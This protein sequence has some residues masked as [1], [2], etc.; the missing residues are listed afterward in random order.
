[1]RLVGGWCAALVVAALGVVDGQA[2]IPVRPLGRTVAVSSVPFS[3][4]VNVRQLAN[5]R[6]LVNDTRRR[7]VLSLDSM[8]ANSV[9]VID[10]TPGVPNS[11]GT[12]ATAIFPHLGDSTLFLDPTST[13]MILLDPAGK[14]VRHLTS[15]AGALN[16]LSTPQAYGYARL[17]GRGRL[18]YRIAAARGRPAAGAPPTA[19]PDS[20]FVV[21][22]DFSTRIVDTLGIIRVPPGAPLT[23]GPSTTAPIPTAPPLIL[24]TF[25]GW[26]TTS[27]GRVGFVRGRDYH[28]DWINADGSRSASPKVAYPWRRLSDDDKL[29]FA[30][31]ATKVRDSAVTAM[32]ATIP[33]G[34]RILYDALG[35]IGGFSVPASFAAGLGLAGRAATPP[36]AA[37][38]P[39]PRPTTPISPLSVPDYIPPFGRDAVR[40]DEDGRLW[41]K[42]TPTLPASAGVAYDIIDGTGTLVDRVLIPDGKML[43]GFGAGGIVYLTSRDGGVAKVE[44]VRFR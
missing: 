38:P 19:T 29:R 22:Y 5:G 9:V 18:V 39:T 37:V 11:Y 33:T 31:S 35:N 30:D 42:A 16:Y 10:S 2:P 12:R 17:D 25:D 1:M 40:A 26:A 4:P 36:A 21:A 23:S 27:T 15:P 32:L 3:N 8:L 6:V 14:V 28:V 41:V 43:L 44:R 24:E 34:S 7:L 13:S 20:A